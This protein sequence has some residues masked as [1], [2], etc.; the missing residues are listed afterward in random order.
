MKSVTSAMHNHLSLAM[1]TSQVMSQN[2]LREIRKTIEG[3]VSVKYRME[4]QAISRGY[5]Q[6]CKNAISTCHGE[7]CKYHF[8]RNLTPV[9]FLIAIVDMP[10][11]RQK[12]LA[13]LIAGNNK[14]QCPML[15]S[16]GCFFSFEQRPVVC[17]NAYPCFSDQAYW[18]EKE[19]NAIEF[20]KA[21]ALLSTKILSGN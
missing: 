6:A 19:K 3:I 14:H 1:N 13:E 12:A 15:I 16:T 18:M 21:F 2:D 11:R 5:S 9:D 7:C 17:T 20:K 4:H 10:D 8:P